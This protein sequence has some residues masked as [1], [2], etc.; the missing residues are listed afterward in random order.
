MLVFMGALGEALCGWLI[1][2]KPEP[3]SGLADRLV[4]TVISGWR[5]P[6]APETR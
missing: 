1:T 5:S 2:G 6:G 3:T 4:D